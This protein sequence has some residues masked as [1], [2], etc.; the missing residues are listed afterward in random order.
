MQNTKETDKPPAVKVILTDKEIRALGYVRSTDGA[1]LDNRDHFYNE[2]PD[3]MSSYDTRTMVAVSK[4]V[5]LELLRVY[6]EKLNAP[7]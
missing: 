1:I 3:P 2:H 7:G 4:P 5:L 6:E